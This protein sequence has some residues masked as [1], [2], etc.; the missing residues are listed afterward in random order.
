MKELTPR[1]REVLD[2]IREYI[3]AHRYPPTFREIADNYSISVKGA[4]DHVAALKK[5]GYAR[6]DKRSRTIELVEVD[7]E[8]YTD[9]VEVPILGPVA[10]GNPIMAEG[11]WEGTI[12]LHRSMLK[13]D[14]RYFALLVRGDSMIDAGIMD[15]DTAVIEQ[16]QTAENGEIVVAVVNEATTMKRY[17]REENRIR[18]QPENEHYKPIYSQDVRLLGRLAAIIRNY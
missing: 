10:A 16:Q 14:R 2:F 13:K 9:I 3:R 8:F 5:K 17:F 6:G 15:G 1:Q 7:T 18:L 4:Y 11:N 12:S